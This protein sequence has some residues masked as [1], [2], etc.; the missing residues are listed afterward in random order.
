MSPYRYFGEG[1]RSRRFD[2]KGEGK[3]AFLHSFDTHFKFVLT[4]A[5]VIAAI[6]VAPDIGVA[7]EQTKLRVSV[8]NLK[9][10]GPIPIQYAY[11][12]PAQ[13][14]HTA[15]GA[16]NNPL[17]K[18]S[19]GPAATLSYAIIVVDTDVP[20][21]FDDANKEGKTIAASLKRR[22]FFHMVLV[23]IPAS[24][25]EIGMGADSNGMTE[26]GKPPGPTPN[27]LRGINDYT[28]ATAGNHGGYDGPCPPWNDE[29]IHHYHFIVYA[30]D[31]ASLG[32]TGNFRGSEAQEAIAKHTLARGAIVGTYTQNPALMKRK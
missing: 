29:R 6:G 24:K 2:K 19:K 17:I 15:P 10:N 14:G 27:G 21:V 25:T 12:V 32:L 1:A 30:L 11:C 23:D 31:V 16:N 9:N 5:A 7:A 18:W 20:T 22:D 3:M 8:D 26:G 28:S 13:Q 4:T